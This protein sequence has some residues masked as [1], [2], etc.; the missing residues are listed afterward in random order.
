VFL[1][2]GTTGQAI[3]SDILGSRNTVLARTGQERRS[4]TLEV[5]SYHVRRRP[6]D[7]RQV[8]V[9]VQRR[10]STRAAWAVNVLIVRREEG[11]GPRRQ[12]GRD[13]IAIGLKTETVHPARL[14]G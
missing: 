7:S 5:G 11:R 1:G 13:A 3:E 14:C 4:W 9:D 2:G 10:D 12:P 8:D 6:R